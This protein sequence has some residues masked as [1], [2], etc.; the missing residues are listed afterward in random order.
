METK[1]KIL[2]SLPA[3]T[4]AIFTNAAADGYAS[5]YSDW[6]TTKTGNAG[7]VSRT[8]WRYADVASW[9]SCDASHTWNPGDGHV[10]QGSY[11]PKNCTWWSQGSCASWSCNSWYKNGQSCSSQFVWCIWTCHGC[12][13]WD[14]T[15]H[16]GD[17]WCEQGW[18]WVC[19][20]TWACNGWTCTSYNQVQHTDGSCGNTATCYAVPTAWNS[21]SAWGTTAYSTSTSRKVESRT[22]YS[23]PMEFYLDVNGTLDGV[24]SGG[25]SGYGTFDLYVNGSLVANDVADYY[26]KVKMGS[27][28]EI[29]DIKATTGH[30]YNGV[31][32]GALSGTVGS[33][34]FQAARLNFTTNTYAV[35]VNPNGGTLSVGDGS[36]TKNSNGTATFTTLY[37]AES[38]YSLGITASRTGYTAKGIYDA[39]S[40]GTKL[41]NNGGNVLQDGKYW[42]TSNQWIYDGAKNVNLY[43]QWEA[44]QYTLTVNPNGGSFSDGTTAAKTASPKLIF[45]AGN[46]NNIAGFAATK[47]GYVLEGWYDSA[48]GGTKVYNADGTCVNGTSYWTNN[49]YKNAGD[50]TVY[51]HWT[52]K[53]I[54]VNFYRNLDSSDTTYATQQ[55]TYGVSG[56]KFNAIGWSKTGYT[57]QGWNV[58]RTATTQQYP[59][60]C[61]VADS[62]INTNYPSINLYA[63]WTA[64]KYTNTL[65]YN[66]NGGSGAPSAQTAT[67]TY[68]STQSTFTLSSTVP[69]KAGHTFA[70]WYTAASGG[71]KVTGS[72]TVGSTDN[73]GNQ[74][75]T[76]Y[77]HWT[78]NYNRYTV[79]CLVDENGNIVNQTDA[80]VSGKTYKTVEKVFDVA[81]NDTTTKT[82][83][84]GKLK[85]KTKVTY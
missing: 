75:V 10:I 7:E 27:T 21:W 51:A 69:T 35:T 73:V 70:G 30:T 9:S 39:V 5:G 62:W 31:S 50:L 63:I 76:L 4:A 3:L 22:V 17:Y 79:E 85:S 25:I 57:F 65:N 15:W 37:G 43:F 55:F 58:T 45:D 20:D 12:G 78:V 42:N 36:I 41:W 40:G 13:W 77:A 52:V 48:T 71:T 82:F 68:P 80:I 61:G 66:A 38:Y 6:S 64:N 14:N 8:E 11:D 19:S 54:T 53:T 81:E 47:T 33:A 49:G 16:S 28:W 1:E 2:L 46:W 29:K 60:S 34:N 18:D 44:N 67:V 74:S 72:Y 32:E 83:C 24:A 59:N 56:Q 23:Y 84:I 26:G